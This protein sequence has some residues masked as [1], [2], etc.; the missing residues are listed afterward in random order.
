M[1]VEKLA[2]W[3]LAIAAQYFL[4]PYHNWHHALDVF[5]FTFY[6]VM[7]GQAS[8][9]FNWQDIFS[10]LISALAHD[11]GHFGV[12]NGFLVSTRA[13]LAT[14]YNDQSVLENM[15]ASK[16]FST[17]SRPGMDFLDGMMRKDFDTFRGKVVGSILATDMAHHFE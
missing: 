14:V 10:L 1:K 8:R 12:N 6:T 9:F 2:A 16:C 11:V 15:H 4:V 7:Q 17:M 5:F 13:E 3:V